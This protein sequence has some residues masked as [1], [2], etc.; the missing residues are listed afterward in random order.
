MKFNVIL[1]VTNM[2]IGYREKA[3]STNAPHAG[4]WEKLLSLNY[5]FNYFG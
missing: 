1:S 5:L 4:G 3:I 2:I